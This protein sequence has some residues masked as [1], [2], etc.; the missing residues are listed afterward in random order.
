MT[1]YKLKREGENEN[2]CRAPQLIR[3]TLRVIL[4]LSVSPYYYV[5]D[6]LGTKLSQG[7][8]NLTDKPVPTVALNKRKKRLCT[9]E[10]YKIG[11][12]NVRGVAHKE[13]ELE[14]E[15]KLMSVHIAVIP[16]TK[17]S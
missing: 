6:I 15:R 3:P 12:R 16:E 7:R 13:M 2:P 4:R 9:V 5:A 8:C 11:V 14:Q 10:R 1:L 17:R